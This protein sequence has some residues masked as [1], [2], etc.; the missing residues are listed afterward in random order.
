MRDR[1]R[2]LRAPTYRPLFL[3]SG[4]T[5]AQHRPRKSIDGAAVLRALEP[6]AVDAQRDRRVAMA[7]MVL[8][9]GD[10]G[11][12]RDHRGGAVVP[13]RMERYAP[14]PRPG[15]RGIEARAKQ[16]IPAQGRPVRRRMVGRWRRSERRS[17]ETVLNS[18][19]FPESHHQHQ[20]V[21]G[22]VK[23]QRV[24]CAFGSGPLEEP[25]LAAG[26]FKDFWKD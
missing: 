24:A 26:P 11:A 18:M 23:P 8:N 3:A 25:E 10:R 20:A 21:I 6:L 16:M 19:S 4:G 22:P 5:P 12:G 1:F 14:Q 2:R 9:L 17:R 7:E 13:E 15:K